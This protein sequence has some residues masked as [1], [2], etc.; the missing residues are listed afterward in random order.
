MPRKISTEDLQKENLELINENEYLKDKVAYLEVLIEILKRND[1]ATNCGRID[2]IASLLDEVSFELAMIE[3][4]FITNAENKIERYEQMMR[5]SLEEHPKETVIW[6]SI[7]GISFKTE[8]LYSEFGKAAVNGKRIPRKDIVRKV[9]RFIDYY[10][11]AMCK[12][13][14]GKL[15]PAEFRRRNSNRTCIIALAASGHCQKQDIA[16]CRY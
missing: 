2:R 13:Y 15:S 1:L 7:P 16:Y 14:L 10:N 9:E 6:I 4:E 12:K 11:N 3:E 8:S 5:S